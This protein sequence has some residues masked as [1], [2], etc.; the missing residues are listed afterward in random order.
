MKVISKTHSC[1]GG[2]KGHWCGGGLPR[3]LVWRGVQRTCPALRTH[4]QQFGPCVPTQRRRPHSWPFHLPLPSPPPPH[5]TGGDGVQDAPMRRVGLRAVRVAGV[6]ER[7]VAALRAGPPHACAAAQ[8]GRA[9]LQRRRLRAPAAA[10]RDVRVHV[11]RRG[12]RLRVHPRRCAALRGGKRGEGNP[13]ERE[14]QSRGRCSQEGGAVRREAGRAGCVEGMQCERNRG[15]G[16]GMG[17]R[18]G[19]E[20]GRCDYDKCCF[21]GGGSGEGRGAVLPYSP[22][23]ATAAVATAVAAA[24]SPAAGAVAA[25][26]AAVASCAVG[27]AAMQGWPFTRA[28]NPKP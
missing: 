15:M 26:V 3:A 21:E 11:R 9:V 27:P 10:E 20:G 28:S 12:V 2:D 5:H 1:G 23:A 13:G 19:G 24:A 7:R 17:E 22:A 25:S 8:A 14:V 16:R 18:G 4:T 6:A